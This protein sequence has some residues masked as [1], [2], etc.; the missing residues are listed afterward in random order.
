MEREEFITGYCRALDAARTV[1]ILLCDGKLTEADCAFGSCPH[2][3]ACPIAQWIN[4]QKD[5]S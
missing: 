1:C 4:E 2:E 3:Q 5:R